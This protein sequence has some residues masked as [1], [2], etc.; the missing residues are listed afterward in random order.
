MTKI[1]IDLDV[2]DSAVTEMKPAIDTINS[3]IKR[4]SKI[5]SNLKNHWQGSD[6]NRFKDKWNSFSKKY[7]D[8][9]IKQTEQYYKYL[10]SFNKEIQ[11][12]YSNINKAANNLPQ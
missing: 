2:L 5:I 11:S 1:K 8:R 9:I 7:D 10:E 12:A 3:E 6:Y 4:Q